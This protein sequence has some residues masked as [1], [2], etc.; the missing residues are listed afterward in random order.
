MHS[1]RE[2]LLIFHA[3][4]QYFHVFPHNRNKIFFHGTHIVNARAPSVITIDLNYPL[5][6]CIVNQ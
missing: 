5:Y 6:T 1:I 2:D 3:F 4:L